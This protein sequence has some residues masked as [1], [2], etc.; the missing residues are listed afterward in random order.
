MKVP[1]A[2]FLSQ[3]QVLHE[4][5]EEKVLPVEKYALAD[6]IVNA[7]L[8]LPYFIF[9]VAPDEFHGQNASVTVIIHGFA[10]LADTAILLLASA[11]LVAA[12]FLHCALKCLR[13]LRLPSIFLLAGKTWHF[14]FKK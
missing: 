8:V 2:L 9:L 3:I 14:F 5:I 4:M 12:C 13:T 6:L 10:C 7:K 11:L 1:S